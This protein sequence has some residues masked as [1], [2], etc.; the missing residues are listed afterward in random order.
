MEGECL[1]RRSAA[2][3]AARMRWVLAPLVVLAACGD[4]PPPPDILTALQALANVADAT[5]MPTQ[6]AGYHYIVVHFVQPVDHADP[7]S[8]TFLQEVSLLHKDTARPLIVHTSGYSDY[9]KDRLVELTNLLGG[10]Q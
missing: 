10:N 7:A 2:W 9:Y 1:P 8:A 3:Q 5:E 4:K 6:T